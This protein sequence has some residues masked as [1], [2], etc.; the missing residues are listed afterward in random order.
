M[1]ALPTL[2]VALA[3]GAAAVV[4][5]RLVGVRSGLDPLWALVRAAAQLALLV[6]V[7]RWVLTSTGWVA[8]W[9]A[10]MAIVATLTS[11]RRIGWDARAIVTAA[12]AVTGSATGA[13]LTV[14]GT[15]A[16]AL[17]PQYLLALGG[18]TLGGVMTVTTLT[19]RHTLEL[20]AEHR[21]EIE[22]LLA[23]GA[24]MRQATSRF[25]ARAI[26]T[27]L[28]PSFDQT[29]S[30]GLVTLPGAFVGA[31]FAGADPLEAGL[32]QVAVLASIAFGGTIAAITTAECLGSPRT[33]RERTA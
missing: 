4:L 28:I 21:A 30:T 17:D 27:A 14:F 6:L 18:I 25:R 23:L 3:M 19:G 10:V 33:L 11:A 15:G 2:L 8:A 29:R 13:L 32:F 5:L 1:N 22:G 9:L 24:T 26:R 12:A 7:L 20:L 31:V 16:L